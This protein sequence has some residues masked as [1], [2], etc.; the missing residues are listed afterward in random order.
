MPERE[1]SEKRARRK[2]TSRPSPGWSR[3]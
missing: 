3:R 2:K 1:K